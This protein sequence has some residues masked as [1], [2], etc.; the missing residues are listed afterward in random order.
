MS[1]PATSSAPA[2]TNHGIPERTVAEIRSCLKRFPQIHWLKLYG[3]RAMGR[4]R[5]GSDIDL[6]YSAD[7]DCSA[8]LREALDQLPTPYLFDVTH[9][10]SLR[11]APLREHI[12][13]VGIP[14]P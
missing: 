3:S 2:A 11:Y 12:E 8:A 13:R 9:W 4:H 10:E 6:A 1:A 5:R 7:E 14:F